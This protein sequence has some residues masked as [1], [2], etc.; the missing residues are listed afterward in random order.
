ME[1]G[2]IIDKKQPLIKNTFNYLKY[3]Q[4]F[5]YLVEFVYSVN[6]LWKDYSLFQTIFKMRLKIERMWIICFRNIFW[7]HVT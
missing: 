6:L 3:L 2:D 7:V 4:P 5:M 1:N